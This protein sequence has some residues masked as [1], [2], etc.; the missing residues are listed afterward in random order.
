MNAARAVEL[1]AGIDE[2]G[3]GPL[4]GPVVA[5]AVVLHPRRPIDGLAD[6]KTLTAAR[7]AALEADIKTRALSWAVAAAEV[8]EIDQL[9]I[10][11]ATMLAMRRAVDALRPA[12]AR[13]LVDGNRV[14]A[15][16]CPAEAVVGGDA[17]HA[18]ISAASILAKESR[19]RRMRALARAWPQYGFE[20]HKGYPTRAHLE[21]LQRHGASRHHRLSFAP[22]RRV[23][24]VGV[25]DAAATVTDT[26]T[27]A[28]TNTDTVPVAAR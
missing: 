1:V 3:R 27:V 4:A 7:R 12:P 15:L 18:A 24:E 10:L 14:P 25:F 21:A 20:R 16:P 26:C 11:G 23:V 28:V 8:A 19:D 13:A 5:A 9:N 6:S 17:L 2:A 22:V